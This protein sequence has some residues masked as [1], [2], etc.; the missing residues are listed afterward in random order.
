MRTHKGGFV[1]TTSGRAVRGVQA[2]PGVYSYCSGGMRGETNLAWKSSVFSSPLT[3]PSQ[4]TSS[5]HSSGFNYT[6]VTGSRI[7]T[8]VSNWSGEVIRSRSYLLQDL[9]D[10]SGYPSFSWSFVSK[11]HYVGSNGSLTLGLSI[12]DL[13]KTEVPNGSGVWT[14]SRFGDTP[15]VTGLTMSYPWN[16]SSAAYTGLHSGS[17][18]EPV[19]GVTWSWSASSPDYSVIGLDCAYTNGVTLS[20][21]AFNDGY[22]STTDYWTINLPAS[23]CS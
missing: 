9:V 19:S 22:A 11:T 13:T 1:N 5:P 17:G 23:T 12:D 4:T 7:N 6:N 21:D 10:A 15:Y 16:P 8:I 20:S 14:D 2:S 3:L 18:G